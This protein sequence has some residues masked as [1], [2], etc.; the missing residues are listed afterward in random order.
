MKRVFFKARYLLL[1]IVFAAVG[2][3]GIKTIYN[4]LDWILL[5]MAEDYIQLTDAQDTDVRQRISKIIAWHQ[6]TQLPLY[7]QDLLQLKQDKQAGLTHQKLDQFYKTLEMRWRSIKHKMAPEIADVLLTLNKKQQVYLF[8]VIREKNDEFIEKYVDISQQER[9]ENI[10]ERMVESLEI[11]FGDMNEAQ[12]TFIRQH[13]EKFKPVSQH[14]IEFRRAWQ[15]ELRLVMNSSMPNKEK[16]AELVRL[17]SKPEVYQ[18]KVYRDNLAFNREQII[19]LILDLPLTKEQ[20][21]HFYSHIDDYV[22]SFHELAV[23]IIQ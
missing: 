18:S 7:S 3:C 22:I 15:K 11:W 4:Q 20:D 13:V 6:K 16:H 5:G 2:G 21:E 12:L 10:T 14:R 8:E 17:F 1:L 23:E 19:K 9:N